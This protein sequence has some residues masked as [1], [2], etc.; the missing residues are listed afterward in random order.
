[1]AKNPARVEPIPRVAAARPLPPLQPIRPS[2][3]YVAVSRDID[4]KAPASTMTQTP[5]AVISPAG[6]PGTRA[7]GLQPDFAGA[8]DAARPSGKGRGKK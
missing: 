3:P 6:N 4:S 2:K 7:R 1:M 8:A 5:G